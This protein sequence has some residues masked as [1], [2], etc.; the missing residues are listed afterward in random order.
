MK[1]INKIFTGL[2]AFIAGF[3]LI[4]CQSEARNTF[5]DDAQDSSL[6]KA[7]L[8]VSVE[9]PY[10]PAL[11]ARTALPS[12][13]WADYTYTLTGIEG[14][15][16]SAQAEEKT[17]YSSRAYSK[18][19]EAV[20]LTAASY[21]FTMTAYS[22][23]TPVLS[24]TSTADLSTGS[25]EV[26]FRMYPVSG[27][28]GSAEITVN[29]PDDGIVSSVKTAWSESPVV[30][31]S[32]K[33]LTA[34]S[35]SGT[36]AKASYTDLESG[37][38][39]YALFYFYDSNGQLLASL[40]ESLVIVAGKTSVSEI[41]I[42][43]AD[44]HRY[45]CALTVN[46]N[47]SV[48]TDSGKTLSLRD[49]SDSSKIYSLSDSDGDGVFT[50]S[51]TE[52]N[53]HVYDGDD[54]TKVEFVSKNKSGN[55]DFYTVSLES[56]KGTSLTAVTSA[57]KLS[58]GSYVVLSGSS[59]T[60][61]AQITSGYETSSSFVI[62][63]NE[64]EVS[65]SAG[66]NLSVSGISSETKISVSGA[67]AIEYTIQYLKDGGSWMDG[68]T[69]PS[70]YTVEADCALPTLS[71]FRK[72]GYVLDGW[73]YSD[74]ESKTAVSSIKAGSKTGNV[75]LS[76]KWKLSASANTS[77]KTIY[78]NGISLIILKSGSATNVYVDFDSDGE[79]DS[80]DNQVVAVDG[81]TD[82]TGYDLRAGNED[83]DPIA[84]D[85]TFTMKGG[86]IAS[87]TGMGADATNKSVLN[88]S[89][90]SIIGSV[91]TDA[92]GN[93]T[94]KGV[95]L[96]S[97][98]DEQV[99]VNG[100]M[101]GDYSVTLIT[102]YAY[103]ANVDHYIGYI[104]NSS[105]ASFGKFTCYKKN[106]S[107]DYYTNSL[108]TMKT[109]TEDG[110]EKIRIRLANP[111]PIAMPGTSGDDKIDGDVDEG[112]SLGKDRISIECSVFSVIVANGSFTVGDTTIE[113]GTSYLAQPNE[114][115]YVTSLATDTSYVYMHIVSATNAITAENA[116]KFLENM[117]FKRS[118]SG[119][120]VTVTVNLETVPYS[121][122]SS[123]VSEAK[124]NTGNDTAFS[125]FNGSFY[126]G[127]SNKN[128]SGNETFI[129]WNEAY[130]AAKQKTFNGLKGYLMNMTS[131]VENNYIATQMGLGD[132]WIGGAR[133]EVG[134]TAG[135]EGNPGVTTYDSDSISASDLSSKTYVTKYIWQ[136]GPEAGTW[137]TDGT[138]PSGK[139]GQKKY[140]T[141]STNGYTNWASGEPN[142]SLP[143]SDGTYKS[144]QCVHYYSGEKN[145]NDYAN[146]YQGVKAYIVEFTPYTTSYGTQVASYQSIQNSASY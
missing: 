23:S 65:T 86:N 74:D 66:T 5:T 130:N 91:T 99:I 24:G 85:F 1:K 32:E 34:L 41:T 144:E 67:K 142:D 56:A 140:T 96:P 52:G 20:T 93:I 73:I 38:G 125:Y 2:L 87:I 103:E 30:L 106:D 7:K 116:S 68:Y 146:D 89:G 101:T 90:E 79:I 88:I 4:S 120:P 95:N 77:T 72:T 121:E 37:K 128:S 138:I 27:S 29:I 10:A 71:N 129:N 75:T 42:T 117:T 46:K 80:G 8:Y 108:I 45:A 51:V 63:V 33:T 49:S 111:A 19:S 123:M 43:A 31:S 104:G 26:S 11:E 78:A 14:Y 50:G 137:F 12:I 119:T 105:W 100:Q 54:D 18:I 55:L 102:Q 113:G 22:G 15:G 124:S 21:S 97:I 13:S 40:P 143:L 36:S 110:A 84:S 70:S 35:F 81:T 83:N 134:T 16:T 118:T 76:P 62:K 48:W 58:D 3:A 47:G 122:I 64:K 44:Y 139:A 82:F 126:L 114:D 98:T 17:L 59:F 136:A 133:I 141:T 145:W 69:A 135:T 6:P 53:Y 94:A 57:E 25:K 39:Q 9:D 131:K 61:Q 109:E 107:D 92:S 115:T 127:V 60:Y 132:S 28:T 112:F